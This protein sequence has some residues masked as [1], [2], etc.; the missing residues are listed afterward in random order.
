M[1]RSVSA[2]AIIVSC[3]ILGIAVYGWQQVHRPFKGYGGQLVIDVP[4]GYGS[5]EIVDLLIDEGVLE[6][7][8]LS[9]AWLFLSSDRGR[10][11]AG[12]YVFDE[13]L[14]VPGVF[15][16]LAEGKVR[17]YSLTIPEGFRV[18]QIAKRW[19]EAGFGDQEGFLMAAEAALP[20]VHKIN[21]EA[22]SVEGHLFP[23]TYS[24][25]RGISAERA[26]EVM[27]SAFE[28]ALARLEKEVPRSEWPLDLDGTLKLASLIESEVAVPDER[29]LVAS[30][31]LNRLH[32][33]MLLECDPTVVY[34]LIQ[35]GSYHGR[36][37]RADLN[38]DSPYN[39]YRY[40][41][42]P[43]GAISNPGYHSLLAAVRPAE[44]EYLFFVRTDGGRHTF[45]RSLAEHNRA[46]AAY[47]Q[48]SN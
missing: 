35:A 11:Q 20:L 15:R 44:T 25:P 41:N 39:T 47:R 29:E 43:P 14:D 1:K 45:S 18:D 36:L 21:P 34:A 27:V 19:E 6:S 26:V 2:I 28:D 5:R 10:L 48:M 4:S 38:F 32:R 17:L 37:L 24:F 33:N 22:G 7:R 16:V 12:E 40:P 31:F 3:A 46:V 13:P 23:E 42:L 30:V 9:L 8:Y